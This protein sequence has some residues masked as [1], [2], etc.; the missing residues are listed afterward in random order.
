MAIMA[1]KYWINAFRSVSDEEKL[2]AYIDL[3][4]PALRAAGG[5]FLARGIPAQAFKSGVTSRN[6]AP[7]PGRRRSVASAW[8]FAVIVAWFAGLTGAGVVV[9]LLEPEVGATLPADELPLVDLV[10]FAITVVP[11]GIYLTVTEAGPRQASWGKQ[12]AGLRVV[13]GADGDP[14]GPLR[15]ITRTAVKLLPWQLAHLAVARFIVGVD[16]SPAVWTAYALSLLLPAASIGM[17]WR[18]P[19]ARALHDRLAGTRVVLVWRAGRRRSSA[20]TP[21]RSSRCSSSTCW[22]AAGRSG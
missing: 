18:D 1:T 17:A 4:R 9:R 19:Q 16:P 14:P 7:A 21:P 2:A 5:R 3:A 15:V 13:S 8:D 6:A 11:V 20:T 10:V 22:S 12:R